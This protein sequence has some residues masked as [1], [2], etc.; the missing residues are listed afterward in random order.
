[1]NFSRQNEIELRPLKKSLRIQEA[2][3]MLR[4]SLPSTI[5]II[6]DICKEDDLVIAD[7]TQIHQVVMNL[8][9]IASHAV[10]EK[11]GTL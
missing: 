11:G 1:M 4:S 5:E 8:C 7:P 3:K 2:L 9:T 10:R 6:T